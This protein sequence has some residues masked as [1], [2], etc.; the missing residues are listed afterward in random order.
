VQGEDTQKEKKKK[1]RLRVRKLLLTYP[2]CNLSPIFV[3]E[4]L[5]ET[6]KRD[7]IVDYVIPSELHKEGLAEEKTEK[8]LFSVQRN[9]QINF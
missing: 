1:F 5:S 3:L 9:E 8:A 7:K 4:Q 2:R 6:F